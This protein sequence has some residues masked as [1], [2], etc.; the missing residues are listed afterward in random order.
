MH[1]YRQASSCICV[2]MASGWQETNFSRDRR[3]TLT[4]QLEKHLRPRGDTSLR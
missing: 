2:A 3:L 4:A 1:P